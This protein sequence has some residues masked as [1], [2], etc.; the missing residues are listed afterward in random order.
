MGWAWAT[1]GWERL[2]WKENEQEF[3][4]QSPVPKSHCRK[5]A[6]FMRVLSLLPPIFILA[7]HQP[8]SLQRLGETGD[9]HSWLRPS[10]AWALPGTAFIHS[11]WSNFFHV[12]YFHFVVLE[13]EVCFNIIPGLKF[14]RYVLNQQWRDLILCQAA[15]KQCKKYDFFLSKGGN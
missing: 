13:N 12:Q 9:P 3:L 11:S 2:R 10:D 5:T 4:A 14:N 6:Q 7:G 8:S 1:R 15:C